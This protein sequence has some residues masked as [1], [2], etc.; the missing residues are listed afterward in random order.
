[1]R[2]KIKDVAK[3]N[4]RAINKKYNGTIN[5]IDTSSVRCV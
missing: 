5:Y 3:I 4:E 1:M 2:Y